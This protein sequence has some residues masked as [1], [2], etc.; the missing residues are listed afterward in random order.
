MATLL[1]LFT[2]QLLFAFFTPCLLE[3]TSADVRSVRP[4]ENIT[5]P[6]N[7]TNYLE[8]SWYRL[9]SDEVKLLVSAEELKLKKTHS[10]SYNVN[11]SHFKVAQSSSSVSLVIIGVRETDLGFYY[12]GGRT[13]ATHTQFGKLIRLDFT[14]DQHI[15][16]SNSP[17]DP[18]KR[19]STGAELWITMCVCLVSMLMNFICLCVFCCRPKEKLRTSCSCFRNTI[20]PSEK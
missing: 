1:D 12:C 10:L 14:D 5:L 19:R 8:I 9:R 11:K 15:D 20:E 13:D 17:D 4:G 18:D 6:C 3:I 2:L 7:I 16:P